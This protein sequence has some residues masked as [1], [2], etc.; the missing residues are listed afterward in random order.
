LVRLAAQPLADHHLHLLRSAIAPREGV[1]LT[2]KD[3]IR[4]MDEAKI[5]RGVVLSLAYHFGN[6]NRPP[7]ENDWTREQAA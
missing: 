1:A 5:Q 6:P 7:V 2:A 3:L 4:Q